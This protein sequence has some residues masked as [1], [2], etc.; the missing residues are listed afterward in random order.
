MDALIHAKMA[1]I[2]SEC[3]AIGKDTQGRDLP[4]T[5]RSVDQVLA[6]VQPILAKHGVYAVPEVLSHDRTEY[7]T[8]SGTMMFN[9][10]ALVTWTFYAEDGT[11]V[12]ATTLGE[13]SD[14][15][16]KS[17]NKAMTAS[18][19]YAFCMAFSIRTGEEDPDHERPEDR[20]GG[21][22]AGSS[23]KAGAEPDRK[24][25]FRESFK[26]AEA[27]YGKDSEGF[28][29]R[30][31]DPVNWAVSMMGYEKL[32]EVPKDERERII[33]G[34]RFWLEK[35]GKPDAAEDY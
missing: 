21:A 29:R 18:Q 28:D 5:Y 13:G 2:L 32:D 24:A 23:R 1:A 22:V 31:Y 30:K 10:R 14:S 33:R 35:E 27:V 11:M 6:H 9:T 26:A 15:S 12:Q 8:K 19:K 16:D 3:E 17:S 4:Y 7:Q 20:E 25:I 34:I